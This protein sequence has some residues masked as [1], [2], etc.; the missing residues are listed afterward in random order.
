M[1]LLKI[2]LKADGRCGVPQGGVITPRTQKITLVVDSLR[3]FGQQS[4][5]PN[6]VKVAPQIKVYDACLAPNDCLSH[7]LH[8]FMSCLLRT[9]S[10]RSRLEVGLKDWLQDEL[11]RPLHHPVADSGNRKDADFSAVLGYLLP[12]SR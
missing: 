10:K 3:D 12:P 7:T 5:V 9:V 2:M 8:R 11:E 1:H 4:V 6:V